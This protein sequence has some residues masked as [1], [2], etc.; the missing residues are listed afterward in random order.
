M[1][2]V[3]FNKAFC[4]GCGLCVL[5]CP[6]KI[7]SISETESNAKGYFV[8]QIDKPEECIGCASCAIMCPDCV[9][10]VER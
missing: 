4:K 9:I 1:A 2:K 10:E 6:K 5:A 3:T 8:A 7:L